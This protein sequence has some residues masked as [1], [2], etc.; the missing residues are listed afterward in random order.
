[1]GLA[2]DSGS[3]GGCCPN[4]ASC[5]SDSP[6]ALARRSSLP[7]WGSTS[8]RRMRPMVDCVTSG[9]RKR[10]CLVFRVLLLDATSFDIARAQLT[11]A[12]GGDMRTA[13][14]GVAA[15]SSNARICLKGKL[16]TACLRSWF[17]TGTP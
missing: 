9:F 14:H 16:P 2:D 3:S 13:T 1:M 10:A 7:D 5:A 6:N 4:S 15:R 8:S 11:L 17:S 12:P